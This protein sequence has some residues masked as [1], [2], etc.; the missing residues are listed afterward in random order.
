MRIPP[1]THTH[2]ALISACPVKGAM[3]LKVWVP[4]QSKGNMRSFLARTSIVCWVGTAKIEL[5]NFRKWDPY[6]DTILFFLKFH[7]IRLDSRL[8]VILCVCI[9]S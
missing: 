9:L 8:A 5:M 7:K 1:H 4:Y 3:D 2:A 6:R